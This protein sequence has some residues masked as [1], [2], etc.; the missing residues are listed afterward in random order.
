MTVARSTRTSH[1]ASLFAKNS[2]TASVSAVVPGE[3]GATQ[4]L[5]E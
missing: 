2:I 5:A 1:A 4:S 3:T